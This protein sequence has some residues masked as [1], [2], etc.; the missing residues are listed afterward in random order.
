[1]AT[2]S[3]KLTVNGTPV[4]A[5]VEPRSMLADFLRHELGLTGTHLGCEHGVCGACTVLV[6]GDA[7]R[8]CLMLAVQADGAEVV[9]VEGLAGAD[10]TLSPLQ[11]AFRDAP[12]AAVRLLHA[13]HPDDADAAAARPAGHR[14]RRSCAS[15]LSGN[16]CRCTGYPGIVDAA[17][18]VAPRLRGEGAPNMTTRFFGR[19]SSA[20]RTRRCSRAPAAS[21][22]TSAAGHAARRLRAQPYAHARIGAIDTEAARA[23]PGVRAVLTAADLPEV[24]RGSASCCRCRTPRSPSRSRR[25]RWRATRSASSASRWP[26]SS[27]RAASSPRTPPRLV[28]VEYDPLPVVA[29]LAGATAADAPTAHAAPPRQRRRP[30][31][32]GLRRRRRRLRQRRACRAPRRSRSIAA[33]GNPIECR[34]VLARYDVLDGGLHASGRRPRRR[35]ACAAR[36]STC[37]RSPETDIRVIAPDVGGGFG[38]KLQVYPEEI[39]V[40]SARGCSAAPVKWIEDRREHFLTHGAGARPDLDVRDRAST[41]RARLLGHAR[42]DA[43]RPG[44]LPALRRQSAVHLGATRARALRRCRPT[45]SRRASRIT[46]KVPATP[47]RGAG[48]PQ[49]GFAMERLLDRAARRAR[50]STAPRCAGA[51]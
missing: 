27:R 35:T 18:E 38:P 34:A 24:V 23:M 20:S 33:R 37:W 9:T 6:D 19:R 45:G 2:R 25:C 7:V 46:N 3:V 40:P 43:A 26:S 42:P 32:G 15:E 49:A 17:L 14:P 1:M 41:P 10:G 51:T 31:R 30:H 44:R 39:V 29:D 22:T 16:L 21:S 48:R 28:F 47:M 4:E 50:A 36:W 12:R 8:G 11:E 13:G 5:E